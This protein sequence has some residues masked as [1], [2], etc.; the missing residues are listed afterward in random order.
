MIENIWGKYYERTK[1]L[2]PRP[3]LVQAVELV[4]EKNEALDLGP[5]ALT[6]VKYL[7]SIGFSHVT[8][9]DR[10]PVSKEAISDFPEEKVSYVTSSFENFDFPEN[11]YDLINAQYSLPFS[12]P[13]TFEKVISGA[14]G[15]LKEN[16]ILVGQF[17]GKNDEWTTNEESMTF[18]SREEAEKLLSGLK[19]VSFEEVES[20]KKTASGVM[21]H[22]H[23]FNFVAVK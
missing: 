21:K 23:V 8:A 20:D 16:G 14:I 2:P 9:V 13:T 19:V 10:N 15:A 1:D 7:L 3:T 4:K 6:D 11:K 22:W 17:F 12:P 18:H 5:G